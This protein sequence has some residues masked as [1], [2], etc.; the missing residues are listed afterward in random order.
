[1][2]TIS[3]A[4]KLMEKYKNEYGDMTLGFLYPDGTL[5]NIENT[6]IIGITNDEIPGYEEHMMVFGGDYEENLTTE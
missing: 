1:M 4:I 5:T 2:I 6:F 3:Q